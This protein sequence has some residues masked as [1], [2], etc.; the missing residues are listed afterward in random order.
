LLKI[1]VTKL[2]ELPGAAKVRWS[3]DV[4]PLEF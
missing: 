2:R 1:V 4:D 3:V